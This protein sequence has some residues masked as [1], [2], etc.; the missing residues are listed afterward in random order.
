MANRWLML[1]FDL[2][3]AFTVFAASVLALAGGIEAG[4]AGIAITQAQNFVLAMYWLCRVWTGFE[5]DLTRWRGCA[6]TL[7]FRRSLLRSSRAADHRLTGRPRSTVEA[8]RSRI[9]CSSMLP[10]LT[11][12]TGCRL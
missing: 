5:M 7:N 10:I 2:M 1:R 8:F 12:A 6:S 9:W 4:L 3:G 11:G